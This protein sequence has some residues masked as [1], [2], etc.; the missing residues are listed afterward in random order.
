MEATGLQLPMTERAAWQRRMEQ[1]FTSYVNQLYNL[2]MANLANQVNK[3]SANKRFFV[4]NPLSWTRT[5]YTDIAYTG[6]LPVHV[7]D[8]STSAEI[9]SQVIN[10][11][12]LQYLRVLAPDVP[13]VGYKVFEIVNGA[14]SVFS[15]AATINTTTRTIDNDLFYNCFYKQWRNYEFN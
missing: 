10:K 1:N 4:F 9:R 11:N 12:G 2:S 6:T 3:A 15:D 5:D 8:V 13:S 7:T 14:G